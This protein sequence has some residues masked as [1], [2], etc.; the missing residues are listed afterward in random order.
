M[1][2][3]SAVKKKW[4]RPEQV[5]EILCCC[6]KTVQRLRN[7]GELEFRRLNQRKFL[8]SEIGVERFLERQSGLSLSQAKGRRDV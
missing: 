2:S 4:L 1:R 8:Y 5:A 7:N 3:T 6:T